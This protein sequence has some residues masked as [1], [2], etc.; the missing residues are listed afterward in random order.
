MKSYTCPIC[1]GKLNIRIGADKAECD[2]CGRLAE[3]DATDV[4]Q[5]REVYHSAERAMRQNTAAGYADAIRQLQ[6]IAFIDEARDKIKECEQRL[7]ELRASRLQRQEANR[8]S[9]RRNTRLGIV[10]LIL[11]LLLCAAALAGVVYL[12]VRWAQGTLSKGA[13]IT[14]LAVA[15]AAVIISVLGRLFAGRGSDS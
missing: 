3:I 5:Y 12:I 14:I 15:A 4:A 8:F 11:T 9:D 7:N 10:L 1:G 2:S 13:V 6:T